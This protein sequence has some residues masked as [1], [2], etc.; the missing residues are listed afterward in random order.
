MPEQSPFAAPNFQLEMRT[1]AFIALGSNL[2]DSK[3][4]VLRAMNRLQELADFPLLRS[5]LWQ[6]SPVDCPPNSPLFV[7]AV[8]GL[9]PRTG[10]SP[11]ALLDQL[12]TFEKEFG[13]QPKA[14]LNEPRLLDLDLISFREETRDTQRL[15]LPHPRAHVRRFVLLPLSEIAPDLVLAGQELNVRQLLETLRSPEQAVRLT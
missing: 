6:S 11:E 2:G 5:S 10:A 4:T 9:L 13:R 14:V 15:T 1:L 7:N 8:V 3:Q 12:Q